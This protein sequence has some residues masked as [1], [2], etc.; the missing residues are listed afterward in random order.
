MTCDKNID[1]QL[2]VLAGVNSLRTPENSIKSDPDFVRQLEGFSLTTAEILY[3]MPD[4][5]SILQPFIWQD[6]DVA[7][8]FP[9]LYSFLDFWERELDGPIHSVRI[10]HRELLGPVE[11]RQA[12]ELKLN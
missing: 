9:K 11:I 7:P 3:R 5:K 4:A 2:V 12:Q 10:A 8:K 6:N 1:N